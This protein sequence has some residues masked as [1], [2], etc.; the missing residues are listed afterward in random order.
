MF[1]QFTFAPALI[2]LFIPPAVKSSQVKLIVLAFSS[3]ISFDY[4]IIS[5]PIISLLLALLCIVNDFSVELVLI[6]SISS[7]SSLIIT[8]V[9]VIPF[10]ILRSYL[11]ITINFWQSLTPLSAHALFSITLSFPPPMFKANFLST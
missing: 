6:L 11:S 4:L 1:F 7:L 10:L 3:L 5:V 8:S 2:W 9:H